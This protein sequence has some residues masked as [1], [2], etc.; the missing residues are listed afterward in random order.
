MYGANKKPTLIDV[1]NMIRGQSPTGGAFGN[2][3]NN[4]LMMMQQFAPTNSGM[5]NVSNSEMNIMKSLLAS[6]NESVPMSNIS[7]A[8]IAAFKAR[9]QVMDNY[10]SA[11]GIVNNT[12]LPPEVRNEAVKQIQIIKEAY[13]QLFTGQ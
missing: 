4:E 8:E 1:V 6:N 12:Q 5:G 2:L 10:N 9:E 3:S 11:L 13:P 7:D